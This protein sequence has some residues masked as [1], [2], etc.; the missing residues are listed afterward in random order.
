MF[1][2]APACGTFATYQAFKGASYN[3][4]P[5]RAKRLKKGPLNSVCKQEPGG[6]YGASAL[7]NQRGYLRMTGQDF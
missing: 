2:K 5:M 4:F 7:R 6:R 3:P 1:G